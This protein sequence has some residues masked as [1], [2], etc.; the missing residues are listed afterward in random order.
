MREWKCAHSFECQWNAVRYTH[1]RPFISTSSLFRCDFNHAIGHIVMVD[2]WW[3]M[4]MMNRITRKHTK[5]LHFIAIQFQHWYEV[6]SKCCFPLSSI[7]FVLFIP[8]FHMFPLGGSFIVLFASCSFLI[9]PLLFLLLLLFI[10][11][12]FYCAVGRIRMTSVSV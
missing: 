7:L 8:F 11:V 9:L 6:A 5:K 1:I 12:F 2:G 10:L 4:M 3:L